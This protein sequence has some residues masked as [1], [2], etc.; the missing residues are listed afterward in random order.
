MGEIKVFE[1]SA[2]DMKAEFPELAEVEEFKNLSNR[3][4]KFVWY[5]SNQTSPLVD[6]GTKERIKEAIEICYNGKL[7]EAEK[8]EYIAGVFG[9]EMLKAINRMSM[10]D[11]M[12]RVQAKYNIEYI[13][14]KLQKI[15]VIADNELNELEADEKKKYAE[16]AIK[17]ANEMPNLVSLMERKFGIKKKR[18]KKEVSA[19]VSVG[20]VMDE[21]I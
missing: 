9:E 17:I 5:L 13:F 4:L 15:I 21:I 2:R 19:E 14:G 20:D 8:D 10:I 6:L 16:L 11:P 3:D 12:I 7:P 1:P 18:D